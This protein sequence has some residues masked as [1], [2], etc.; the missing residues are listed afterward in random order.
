MQKI[1]WKPSHLN[2]KM[3]III[4]A[5]D[6]VRLCYTAIESWLSALPLGCDF[7]V[8]DF[9]STDSTNAV[10]TTLSKYAPMKII[11][12]KWRPETG[13]TAI[14]IATQEL[15]SLCKTPYVLN[16]QACEILCDDAINICLNEPHPWTKE[17]IGPSAFWFKHFWG[18]FRFDGSK[19]Y[20]YG[21]APRIYPQNQTGL[22]HGDGCWPPGGYPGWPMRGTIHRYSYCF[23]NQVAAKSI[24]HYQLYLGHAQTPDQR[25]A[26]I[27]FCKSNPNYDGPHPACV[28]HLVGQA[29]YDIIRSWAIIQ[30]TLEML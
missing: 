5:H 21:Q 24:N 1:K 6:L 9:D 13:G 14:G 25:L 23:D 15:L 17:S 16:L 29:N 20:S 27:N 3:T 8:G 4:V 30:P 10:Y 28:Q 2:S 11:H 26:S 7:L 18:N 12:R 19:G 22:D